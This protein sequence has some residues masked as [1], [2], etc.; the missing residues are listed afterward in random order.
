MRSSFLFL[1]PL[2]FLLVF[3]GQAQ[4]IY[5]PG[6]VITLQGD[7]L[8]GQIGETSTSKMT[9]EVLFRPE[10]PAGSRIRYTPEEIRGFVIEQDRVYTAQPVHHAKGVTTRFLQEIVVGRV[11]L[12]ETQLASL[13]S[14]YAIGNGDSVV[15]LPND[16]KFHGTLN[17]IF[18][19][20]AALRLNNLEAQK[21]YRYDLRTLTRLVTDYTACTSSQP[22]QIRRRHA[23]AS[24]TGGIYAGANLYQIINFASTQSEAQ[25]VY[26]QEVGGEAG[27]YGRV[28][29]GHVG[30]QA[31]LGYASLHGEKIYVNFWGDEYRYQVATQLIRL[32]LTVQYHLFPGHFTPFVAAGGHLQYL[33]H[34]EGSRTTANGT[35]TYLLDVSDLS[36]GTSFGIGLHVPLAP[37]ALQIQLKR[38]RSRLLKYQANYGEENARINLYQLSLGVEF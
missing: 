4:P 3:S 34:Q 1:L 23:P 33:L 13:K 18:S 10:G 27:L 7:T 26:S 2:S 32:P 36:Y 6:A 8:H 25:G 35:S 12:Y 9:R 16:R 20:C 21:K 30:V 11:T 37:V 24:V 28:T 31:S 38:H 14:V 17:T 29:L 19:D 15:A 5:R 22:V